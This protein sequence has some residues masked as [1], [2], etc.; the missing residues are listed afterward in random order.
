MVMMMRMMVVAR[1]RLM[2]P[3]HQWKPVAKLACRPC[4]GAFLLSTHQ[5]PCRAKRT[6]GALGRAGTPGTSCAH[7]ESKPRRASGSG[8]SR[9]L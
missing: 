4:G 1:A 9:V 2:I 8:R 7:G 5:D 3:Q 6:P